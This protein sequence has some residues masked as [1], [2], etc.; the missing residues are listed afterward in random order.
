MR[1]AVFAGT[2]YEKGE[3]TLKE[4]I[5]TCFESERGPGVVPSETQKGKKESLPLGIIAPHAAYDYS[6]ACAAW[7]Y[8]AIGNAPLA[9]TYI[10]I[11]PAHKKARTGITQQTFVTP[12]GM[13]R[14]DQDMARRLLEKG[15]LKEDDPLHEEEHG[16][17]VQLPF[18]Q[19]SQM[20][21][22]EKIKILP[23]IVNYDADLQQIAIDIKETLVETNKRA[24][25]IMSSDFTHY[26]R[27]YKFA[28]YL[29]DI[30]EN[31]AVLDKGAIDKIKK[32]D[33]EGLLAYVEESMATIC[34]S[35]A[36][37]LGL[38]LLSKTKKVTLEQ[39][40][41]SAVITGDDKQSVSY[42][43]MVFK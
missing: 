23:I 5:K 38:R 20:D 8:K 43:S 28:P 10:I 6:G 36:I 27:D 29:R 13:V 16:I 30:Q 21:V 19:Y 42:A 33:H 39:Y 40:Y 22:V 2:F 32:L 24:V 9:D 14:V 25:I 1:N 18:L 15:T 3:K 7:A 4:Q 37:A 34:G 35:H 17:E 11:A 26:G 41:T 12:L 31:I